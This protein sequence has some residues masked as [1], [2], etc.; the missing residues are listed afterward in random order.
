VVIGKKGN[1]TQTAGASKAPKKIPLINL[2]DDK[3][4]YGLIF[5]SKLFYLFFFFFFNI[6]ICLRMVLLLA[7]HH[8][9]SSSNREEKQEET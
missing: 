9:L 8:F 5:V 3:E 7:G 1:N 6:S 4:V 2:S